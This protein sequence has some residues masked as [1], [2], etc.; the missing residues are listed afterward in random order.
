MAFKL[1][2]HSLKNAKAFRENINRDI[3]QDDESHEEI[4]VFESW[5]IPVQKEKIHQIIEYNQNKI[6]GSEKK[7]ILKLIEMN[8]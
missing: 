2:K 7:Q 4:S 5:H 1:T 3:T 8:F 6:Q